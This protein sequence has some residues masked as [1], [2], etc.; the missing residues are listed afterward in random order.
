MDCYIRLYNNIIPDGECDELIKY[1]NNNTNVSQ[2]DFEWRRC[3]CLSLYPNSFDQILYKIRDYINLA[4]ERY[5]SDINDIGG[6]GTLN[7][8]NTLEIPNML[9]YKHDTIN[10]NKFNIHSDSWSTESA[11]RQI[12]VIIYLNDVE[13]GGETV[14][15]YDNKKIKPTRGTILLFPSNFC[16]THEAYRPISN[17]KYII[18][19]WIHF[20]GSKSYSTIGIK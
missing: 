4:F 12:S 20:D 16:Y 3:G 17:D 8:C 7:F 1:Y 15:V 18:V 2:F 10:P 13:E 19:S 6:T 5:K 9:C 11:A 14:F